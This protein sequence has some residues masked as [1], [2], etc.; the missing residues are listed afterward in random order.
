M[1]RSEMFLKSFFFKFIRI[2]GGKQISN[3][4]YIL[5]Y[6]NFLF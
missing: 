3:F 6:S 1:I 2:Q 5:Q 4:I